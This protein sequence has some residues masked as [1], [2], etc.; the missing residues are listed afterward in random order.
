MFIKVQKIYQDA[1]KCNDCFDNK[2]YGLQRGLISKAQPRWIGK[3]YFASNKRVVMVAINPGNVGKKFFQL[4]IE[5][6]PIS[7]LI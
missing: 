2:D 3:D 7:L 6:P 5:K 4:R 1:I